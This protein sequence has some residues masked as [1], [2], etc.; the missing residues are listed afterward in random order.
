MPTYQAYGLTF[1]SELPLPEFLSAPPS[2][3]PDVNVVVAPIPDAPQ[4]SS[5]DGGCFVRTEGDAV[6][7]AWPTIGRYRA[8]SGRRIVVDP[9]PGVA[10]ETI[11]L[12]VLGVVLGVLL[13]QRGHF[14]L[15]ASAVSMAGQAVAFVGWK[16]AGKSTMAATLQRRG[17]ALLTD[18]VL[19]VSVGDA[20]PPRV[21]PAFPQIKLWSETADALGASV[22]ALDRISPDVPKYAVRDADAFASGAHPLRAVYVLDT[23]DRI[24]TTPLTGPDA[25]AALMGQA[26]AARFLGQNGVGPVGFRQGARLAATVPIVRLTRPRDLTQLDAVAAHVEDEVRAG[27]AA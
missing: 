5:V 25:F 6:T 14:T 2:D 12:P 22:D 16:G 15:H 24:A 21:H 19:A 4:P 1:G 10:P 7:F 17:H 9:I 18:D 3:A 13:H 8:E 20:E 26:Y 27:V 23:G 11:R